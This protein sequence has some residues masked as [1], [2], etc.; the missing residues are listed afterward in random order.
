MGGSS[1]LG[2]KMIFW[3]NT[4]LPERDAHKTHKCHRPGGS[5]NCLSCRTHCLTSHLSVVLQ[6]GARIWLFQLHPI[7]SKQPG[8]SEEKAWPCM[9]KGIPWIKFGHPLI[10]FWNV[11]WIDQQQETRM[12]FSHDASLDRARKNHHYEF[13]TC[14]KWTPN[15][16]GHDIPLYFSHPVIY[17]RPSPVECQDILGVAR[18][19]IDFR[20]K[21]GAVSSQS[22]PT[23]ILVEQRP[24]GQ[25]WF[26][27]PCNPNSSKSGRSNLNRRNLA[28][29][30][31]SC[32]A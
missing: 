32:L 27:D 29:R 25:H 12:A 13:S 23:W 7:R 11:A 10:C 24:L 5:A 17:G 28:A 1:F 22:F 21:S 2:P 6:R 4:W 14:P 26:I 18:E 9:M 31:D 19:D 15:D 8:G 3:S 20:S 16:I 30:L